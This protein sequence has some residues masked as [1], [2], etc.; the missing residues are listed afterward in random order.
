MPPWSIAMMEPVRAFA[1]KDEAGKLHAIIEWQRFVT[2]RK[3][4]D[5]G[6]GK[7]I[8]VQKEL[9]TEYDEHVN[10][11][12]PGKYRLITREGD[13]IDLIYDDSFAVELS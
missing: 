7:K 2:S 3:T 13:E 6:G 4:L 8:P 1:A 5:G 10:Q 11:V 12:G 9:R